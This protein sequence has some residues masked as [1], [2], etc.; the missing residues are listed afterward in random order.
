MRK[1]AYEAFMFATAYYMKDIEKYFREGLEYW[2]DRELN[3]TK[4]NLPVF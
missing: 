4:A 3:P 2:I 1:I